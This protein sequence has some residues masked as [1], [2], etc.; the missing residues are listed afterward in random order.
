[1]A[2]LGF[3]FWSLYARFNAENNHCPYCG[4]IFHIRL[5]RKSLLIEARKCQYC[6]LIFRWPA[7]SRAKAEHFYEK[8]YQSEIIT[9]VPSLGELSELRANGFKGSPYERSAHIEI[10]K[11]ICPP[12]ARVLD[13]GASWGYIGFQ[14]QQAGYTVEGFELSRSRAEFG[15]THL[16]LSIHSLWERLQNLPR[17]DL[18]F[19]AHTLE[20]VYDLWSVLD[21][22]TE[23]ITP[24]GTL[25]VIV[26]N[27]GCR[28]A[29]Q[30]GVRWAPYIGEAHTIAFTADWFQQNIH[31][32]GFEQVE[33]FSPGPTGKDASCNEEELVCVAQYGKAPE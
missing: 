29:R 30:L 28:L 20:H 11:A 19:A 4:S 33:L 12:P 15:R 26:P 1:M 23:V 14:L 16:G 21:K 2:R 18:V 32:H 6:N 7:D 24:G 3:A 22:L 13:F 27:A 5:Q 31:R 25:L 9:D 10:V 8:N 17:F